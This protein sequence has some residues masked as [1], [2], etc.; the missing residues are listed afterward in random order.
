K[1]R[2]RV[3]LPVR[4]VV[5]PGEEFPI[6][7]SSA[8]AAEFLAAPWLSALDASSRQALLNVL[9][10]GQAEAGAVLLGEGQ[11]NDRITFLATGTVQ[12][13]RTYHGRGDEIVATLNAPSVFGETSFFRE[14]PSIVSVRAMTP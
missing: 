6:M 10:E 5:D 7:V 9:C 14:S 12:I 8:A 11:L 13:I 4:P 2:I 3:G 1:N